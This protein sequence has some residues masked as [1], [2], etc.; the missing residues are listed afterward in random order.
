MIETEFPDTEMEDNWTVVVFRCLRQNWTETLKHLFLKLEKKKEPLI[1]HYTIRMFDKTTDSFI[2]SFRILR[3]PKH[4]QMIRTLIEEF[5]EHSEFEINPKGETI[6]AKY[7]MWRNPRGW[8][9]ERCERLNKLSRLALEVIESN[10]SFSD[11]EEVTHL[12]SNMVGIFDKERI[13]FSPETAQVHHL[14]Y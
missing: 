14:K 11:K 3:E 6:F 10:S 5:L 12:F 2:I 9:K 7:H 4:E 13:Y 8:T 1:P